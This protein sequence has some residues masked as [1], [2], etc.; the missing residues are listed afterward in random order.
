[1]HDTEQLHR[2]SLLDQIRPPQLVVHYCTPE[3]RGGVGFQQSSFMNPSCNNNPTNLDCK[4]I[5][6]KEILLECESTL[7]QAEWTFEATL[8]N[9][10]TLS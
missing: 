3:F 8:R 5:M 7:T 4:D 9:N 10:S 2:G 6:C 1:M